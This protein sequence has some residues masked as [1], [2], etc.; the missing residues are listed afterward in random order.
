LLYRFLILIWFSF[1]HF[2]KGIHFFD[3]S[4]SFFT[5]FQIILSNRRNATHG[6]HNSA[7]KRRVI[8][9]PRNALQ[10][11]DDFLTFQRHSSHNSFNSHSVFCTRTRVA[12]TVLVRMW[13]GANCRGYRYYYHTS[14]GVMQCHYPTQILRSEH[15]ALRSRYPTQSFL[16]GIDCS[17]A[18][19]S[20]RILRFAFSYS[21]YE[22]VFV[23]YIFASKRN[24]WN[25]GLHNK[26]ILI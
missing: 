8:E 14:R 3:S 13:V 6:D 5:K 26:R 2:L 12:L 4:S 11:H 23:E 25:K 24:R 15:T 7:M 10:K 22:I 21:L 9:F 18:G 19:V 1:H 20:N 16:H 17:I